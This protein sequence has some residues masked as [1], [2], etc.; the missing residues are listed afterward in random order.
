MGPEESVTRRAFGCDPDGFSFAEDFVQKTCG[1]S[2]PAGELASD[3]KILGIDTVGEL[4]REFCKIIRIVNGFGF[5]W[6]NL[7]AGRWRDKFSGGAQEPAAGFERWSIGYVCN[8]MAQLGIAPW[9]AA[10]V[11]AH[12]NFGEPK[13]RT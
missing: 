4:R 6:L 11:L 8:F 13:F 1:G 5:S 7:L 9:R 12:A 2:I 10:V 3:L